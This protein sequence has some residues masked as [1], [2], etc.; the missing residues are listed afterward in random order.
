MPNGIL[1]RIE[2]KQDKILALLSGQV[3]AGGA[4]EVENTKTP[5]SPIQQP[6]SI[7]EKVEADPYAGVDVDGVTWD[8]RIHSKAKE[9][10]AT[11]GANKGRWKRRKGINDM[12]YAKVMEELKA[13][14]AEALAN[15]TGPFFLGRYSNRCI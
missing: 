7:Q 2:E 14:A 9:P 8:A 10:K 1:E 3:V 15:P 6:T 4:S 5:V 13:K 12:L 11:T